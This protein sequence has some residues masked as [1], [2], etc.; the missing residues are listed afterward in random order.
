MQDLE[1]FVA[2]MNRREIPLQDQLS[3]QV[4]EF[5]GAALKIAGE[6]LVLEKDN[7]ANIITH[8]RSR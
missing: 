3:A 8:H 1:K 5:D 2:E 7:L 4:Y 6:N